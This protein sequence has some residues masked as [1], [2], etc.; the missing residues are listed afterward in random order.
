MVI[1]YVQDY[2]KTQYYTYPSLVH[3]TV[4]T[5]RSNLSVHVT[6]YNVLSMFINDVVISMTAGGSG[7]SSFRSRI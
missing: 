5:I 3:F 1:N 4:F 6:V 2:Y 7:C